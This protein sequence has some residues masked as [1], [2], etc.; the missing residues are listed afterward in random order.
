MAFAQLP[1]LVEAAVRAD[2]ERGEE[3]EEG[4]EEEVYVLLDFSSA[5]LPPGVELRGDL[6]ID[7]RRTTSRCFA[8]APPRARP[9]RSL[10]FFVRRRSTRRRPP[11]S[12]ASTCFAA[13]T[14]KT[15]A[16]R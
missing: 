3:E 16:A 8:R 6:A 11:S 9:T 10:V 13:P 4:E 15:L 12:W 14:R 1:A 7:V 5:E 2:R